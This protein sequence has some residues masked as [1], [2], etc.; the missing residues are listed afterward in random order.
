MRQLR[1]RP[2]PFYQLW[3]ST[4]RLQER[5]DMDN[6]ASSCQLHFWGGYLCATPQSRAVRAVVSPPV[7]LAARRQTEVQGS[8][9]HAGSKQL[10]GDMIQ[11]CIYSLYSDEHHPGNTTLLPKLQFK[12]QHVPLGL[13]KLTTLTPFF[14]LRSLIY[15]L[16]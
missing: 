8:E 7:G 9:Q 3:D 5:R 2:A 14:L 6:H 15:K 12:P 11:R 10:S 13:P 1:T 16:P 4:G